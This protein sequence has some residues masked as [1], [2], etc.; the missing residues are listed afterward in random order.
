MKKTLLNN[1]AGNQF[2]TVPIPEPSSTLLGLFG[3]LGLLRRR[4]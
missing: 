1:F 2:F 3:L 4:R